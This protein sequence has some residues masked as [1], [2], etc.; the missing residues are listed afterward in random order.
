MS[1]KLHVLRRGGPLYV[2]G[3]P[4][5]ERPAGVD[6]VGRVAVDTTTI[7][8][9][10]YQGKEIGGLYFWVP[11]DETIVT[12]ESYNALTTDTMEVIYA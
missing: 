12:D 8:N 4:N 2:A 6:D 5:V 7:P 9:V 1:R 3:D 10:A 11:L